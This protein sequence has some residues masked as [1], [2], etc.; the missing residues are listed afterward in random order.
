MLDL[1][2][3]LDL[4]HQI[5]NLPENIKQRRKKMGLTQ[6]QLA[7]KIGKTNRFWIANLELGRC[8]P[9]GRDLVALAKAL[10]CTAEILIGS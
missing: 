9:Y 4:L 5:M 2:R 8:Q 7:E 10:D 6:K 1:H 3:T